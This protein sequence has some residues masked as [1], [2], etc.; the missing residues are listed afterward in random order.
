MSDS[1]T[2]NNSKSLALTG[3]SCTHIQEKYSA[4]SPESL[5][6][7]IYSHLGA[8]KNIFSVNHNVFINSI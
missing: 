3:K 7:M 6:H 5:L 1:R 2:Q 4:E 8:R